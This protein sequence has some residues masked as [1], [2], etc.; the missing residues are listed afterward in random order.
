MS[1][2]LTKPSHPRDWPDAGRLN[3][4]ALHGR[5]GEKKTPGPNTRLAY[6]GAFSVAVLPKRRGPYVQ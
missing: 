5:P 4:Q 1:R 2:R 3:S 6:R